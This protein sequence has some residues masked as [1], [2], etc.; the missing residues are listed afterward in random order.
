M[1]EELYAAK[2]IKSEIVDKMKALEDQVEDL[3]NENERLKAL[4]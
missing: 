1:E 3:M 2:N 4:L